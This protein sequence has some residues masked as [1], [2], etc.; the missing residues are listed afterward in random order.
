MTTFSDFDPMRVPSPCFV[1]DEAVVRR[2][3][4][5]L[6]NVQ[7]RSGAKVLLAL[8]A[9]SMFSMASVVR[10]FL[11]G[12]CASGLFEARLAREKFGGEVHTYAAGFKEDGLR[13][14]LCISDHVIFNSFKQLKRFKPLLDEAKAHNPDLQIGMRI[15]PQHSEAENPLYDPAAP[16]SRLGIIREQFEE[17][18]V[19]LVDGFH[20]HTLCE[21][22]FA[23]LERTVE[24]IEK[25]LGDLLPQLKWVNFGGG[26][27]ITRA[28][29]DVDALVNLLKAFQTKYEVQAYLEPG[30]AVVL[31][32]GVL[33]SEV[34]DTTWNA[35]A[36]GILD[37]SATA[38]M[39]DVIESPYRPDIFGA[40]EPGEK[41][42]DYRLGGPT[43][44]AGDVFGDYSFDSELEIG[45]RLMFL[46]QAYYTMVKTNTFNGIP[47]PA[48]AIWNSDT[49]KL[50]LVRE[51]SYEDFQSRL[52]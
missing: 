31:N 34:V 36:I 45:Q 35:G 21:Q 39:P 40:A 28:D 1:V 22:N 48:M 46:D 32:A 25:R 7:K 26:H 3:L 18:D 47:L 51:F 19:A 37:C 17:E 15:N 27:H 14:I 4:M 33:V 49:D 5:I 12:T 11:P 38:H 13:D 8:K 29:Y 24:A 20:F 44:L 52:S 16:K 50:N 30:E 41:S 9:F 2:N 43:C 6:D 23:P 42:H 10:E